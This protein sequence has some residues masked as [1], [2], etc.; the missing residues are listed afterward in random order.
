MSPKYRYA[1]NVAGE[2]RIG[3]PTCLIFVDS[4]AQLIK[5]TIYAHINFAIAN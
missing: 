4:F 5:I 2:R 1:P 3:S